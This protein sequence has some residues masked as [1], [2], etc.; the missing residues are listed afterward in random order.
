MA[1]R[2]QHMLGQ[3]HRDNGLPG[4][5]AAMTDCSAPG[6]PNDLQ[7]GAKLLAADVR[8]SLRL[9]FRL[10][11]GKPLSRCVAT[12]RL[13]ALLVPREH[14]HGMRR[15][16]RCDTL[17]RGHVHTQAGAAA[18]DAHERRH[19]PAG[20]AD[21]VP[22]GALHGAAAACGPE[23]GL[24]DLVLSAASVALDPPNTVADLPLLPLHIAAPLSTLIKLTLVR[25]SCS[26][27][28]CRPRSRTS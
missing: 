10:A 5:P 27:T 1:F 15:T 11:K 4:S 26:P 6:C 18:A 20:A 7:A 3:A 24:Q 21:G 14:W 16:S 19:L 9:V 12:L 23:G 8:I 13:L 17:E 22:G 2:W 28:C 25:C